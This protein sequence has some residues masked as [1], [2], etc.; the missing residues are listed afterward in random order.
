[1]VYGL[2]QL[3]EFPAKAA[4]GERLAVQFSNSH[5][6]ARVVQGCPFSGGKGHFASWFLSTAIGTTAVTVLPG[7]SRCFLRILMSHRLRRGHYH[8]PPAASIGRNS[9]R[10]RPRL[11]AR[12]RARSAV[13]KRLAGDC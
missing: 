3:P 1:M 10:L 8:G 5:T 11:F 6:L 9:E 12:Y 7:A 2:H 13:L 4:R